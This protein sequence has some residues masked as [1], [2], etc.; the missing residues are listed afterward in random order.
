MF[1]ETLS[2][3]LCQ[4]F[5]LGIWRLCRS[6]IMHCSF[7][8]WFL[9]SWFIWHR[10]R[11][12]HRFYILTSIPCCLQLLSLLSLLL[13]SDK[14]FSF[15]NHSFFLFSFS[16]FSCISFL[17]FLIL[18]IFNNSSGI[19]N[20]LHGQSQCKLQMRHVDSFLRCD[21]ILNLVNLR[22][23]Y[24]YFK[25]LWIIWIEHIFNWSLYC[26]DEGSS[27]FIKLDIWWSHY[28]DVFLHV[29]N[30]NDSGGV[31]THLAAQ[32]HTSDVNAA[33]LGLSKLVYH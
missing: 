32:H 24:V 2:L 14:F 1:I 16:S 9:W 20:I 18:S 31:E 10:P 23:S 26:Y 4:F 33:I 5:R 3:W 29:F 17:F 7:C 25:Y 15:F 12:C 6:L 19:W 13:L 8:L 27:D 22:F 28:F 11:W 21:T 30:S